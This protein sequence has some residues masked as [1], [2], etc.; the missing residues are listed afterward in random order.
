MIYRE[1]TGTYDIGD[2]VWHSPTPGAGGRAKV[3]GVFELRIGKWCIFRS[4]KI[5][6]WECILDEWRSFYTRASEASLLHRPY[7]SP[8]DILISRGLRVNDINIR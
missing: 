4:Y 2:T 8:Y 7:I 3:I 1:S 6:V 5:V